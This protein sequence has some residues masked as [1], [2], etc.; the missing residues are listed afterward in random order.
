VK[1][2]PVERIS[3][4]EEFFKATSADLRYRGDRAYYSAEGDYIQMPVI[5]AFRDAESFYATLAHESTHLTEH[6][7]RLD[8]EFGRKQW[9]D[10]GYARE[11]FLSLILRSQFLGGRHQCQVLRAMFLFRCSFPW[12]RL[13]DNS[14]ARQLPV[15]CFPGSSL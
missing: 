8:H 2:T 15:F 13:R 9:G 7:S 11:D 10:E 4:A 3:Y 6:S 5:E 12:A 1:T 14:C